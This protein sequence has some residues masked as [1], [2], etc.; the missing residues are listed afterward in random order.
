MLG[1]ALLL[2]ATRSEEPY[3]DDGF[4]F[5]FRQELQESLFSRGF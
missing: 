4:D 5:P 3:C 2:A 1:A